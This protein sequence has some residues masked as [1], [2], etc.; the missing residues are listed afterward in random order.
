MSMNNKSKTAIISGSS[1]GLGAHI[2][3]S[4]INDGYNVVI[5]YF[6]N[7]KKAEKN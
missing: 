2:A 7:K 4:M 1:I 5:T 3:K 6:K